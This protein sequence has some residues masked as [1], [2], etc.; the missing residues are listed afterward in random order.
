MVFSREPFLCEP[1]RSYKHNCTW[2]NRK[3]LSINIASVRNRK[4]QW[5]SKSRSI[6]STHFKVRTVLLGIFIIHY[7]NSPLNVLSEISVGIKLKY[8]PNMSFSIKAFR[9]AATSFIQKALSVYMFVHLCVSQL[10]FWHVSISG[11]SWNLHKTSGWK[12]KGHTDCSK[13]FNS[14]CSMALC[15][16]D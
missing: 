15:L 10:Y 12:V 1:Q 7:L 16:S 9:V 3:L 8:D 14:V 5:I 4:I 13:F 2:F 6:N 11:F